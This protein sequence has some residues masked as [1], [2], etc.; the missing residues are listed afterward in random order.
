MANCVPT[1]YTTVLAATTAIALIDEA[2][3][4]SVCSVVED[5]KLKIIVTT[6]A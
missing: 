4:L 2:K 5:G 1:V 3:L 6:K